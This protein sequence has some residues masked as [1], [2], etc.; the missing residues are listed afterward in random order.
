ME[1][2]LIIGCGWLGFPLAQSLIRN[3]Y[4]VIGTSTSIEKKS[5]FNN[6]NID[7]QYLDL[8]SNSERPTFE[9]VNYFVIAI[10]PSKVSEYSV[11][12]NEVAK[13]YSDL[14]PT[15]KWIFISSTSV[16][17]PSS[18]IA[19]VSI[20]YESLDSNSNLVQT[21]LLLRKTLS[22]S[23]TIIRMA[24]LL[25][26]N[27]HPIFFISKRGNLSN[28]DAPVNMIHLTDAVNLIV[29]VI[30]SNFFG[31]V[32]NGCYPY[33]PSKK[34]FYTNASR[35][36]KL[37]PPKF[38]KGGELDKIVDLSDNELKFNYSSMIDYS[39]K[40]FSS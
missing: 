7:F 32:L 4:N 3:K 11:K 38:E 8:N 22:E 30:Q 21:E 20:P 37:T 1:K 36:F 28:A 29:H 39:C 34:E 13:I 18:R 2:V 26:G 17:K 12:I 6:N 10:P 40:P 15:A 9:E 35:Y 24:G 25:G 31:K 16:Y 23:L 14:N 5:L 33:H 27:R 19:S